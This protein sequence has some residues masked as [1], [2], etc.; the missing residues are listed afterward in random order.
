MKPQTHIAFWVAV[1]VILTAVF[2]RY[3][4][5]VAESFYF[6]SMLLPVVVGTCYFFNLYLVPRY[7]LTKRY[8]RFGLYCLYLLVVSLYLEM[9]VIFVAFIF[10]AEYSFTNMAAVSTDI[11][12][13]AITDYLIVFLFS[14]VLLVRKNLHAESTIV[15]L[16]TE[17]GKYE[18][19]TF[20]IRSERKERTITYDE[21]LYIESLNDYVKIHLA[22]G[23]SPTTKEKISNLEERLPDQFVRIHRSFLV[24]KYA[25]ASFNKEEVEVNAEVLKISRTYK[26][27]ALERLQSAQ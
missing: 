9:I 7:L 24:N 11:F 10:Q 13:L 14:F 26:K 12:L 3:Y 21:V 23:E 6:V 4:P 18:K 16:A 27:A 22:N 25:I 17:K 20:T 8:F 19:G 5:S 1:V 2:S 15:Q